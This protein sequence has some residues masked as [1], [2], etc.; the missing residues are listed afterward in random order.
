MFV[1]A[2]NCF[3]TSEIHYYGGGGSGYLPLEVT[4]SHRHKNGIVQI[5]FVSWGDGWGGHIILATP[6]HPPKF[7]FIGVTEQKMRRQL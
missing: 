2:N 6:L 1:L 4:F 5:V 3:L 7:Q